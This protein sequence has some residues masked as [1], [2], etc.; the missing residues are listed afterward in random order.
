MMDSQKTDGMKYEYTP[1]HNHPVTIKVSRFD[2]V[3]HYVGLC[4][5]KRLGY[6]CKNQKYEHAIIKGSKK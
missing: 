3:L 6:Y 5:K 4:T 1:I 2:S